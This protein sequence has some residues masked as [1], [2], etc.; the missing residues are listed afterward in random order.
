MYPTIVCVDPQEDYQLLLTFDNGEK[1]I[2][3]VKPY[4]GIGIFQ[5]LSDID[6]FNT[7]K[8]SFDTVEWD[9]KADLDP[10]VLFLDSKVVELRKVEM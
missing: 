7:V 2:F 6:L 9:N 1:R 4:L 3:D 8:T 5:E 10:E